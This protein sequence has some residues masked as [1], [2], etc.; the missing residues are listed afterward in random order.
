VLTFFAINNIDQLMSPRIL[1]H[2]IVMV[3]R[4]LIESKSGISIA[5]LGVRLAVHQAILMNVVTS[6]IHYRTTTANA[7]AVLSVKKTQSTQ[8]TAGSVVQKSR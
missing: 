5:R 2:K 4:V 3:P 7:M 6:S 1:H 8:A